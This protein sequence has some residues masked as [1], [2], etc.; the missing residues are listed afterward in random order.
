VVDVSAAEAA[1]AQAEGDDA[2]ARVNVWRGLAGLAEA[3]GDLA[4]FL[5]LF[6]S[7]PNPQP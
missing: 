4:P 3:Q 7:Q 6:Q 2:V 1:L 5:R